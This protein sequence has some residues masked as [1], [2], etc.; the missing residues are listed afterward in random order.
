MDARLALACKGKTYTQGGYNVQDLLKIVRA[1]KLAVARLTREHLLDV[2]CRGRSRGAPPPEVQQRLGKACMGKTQSTGGLNL[3]DL[4]AIASRRGLPHSK[5][6]SR[7]ALLDKLCGK[8][9]R[10]SDAVAIG[11]AVCAMEGSRPLDLSQLSVT[12]NK[13]KYKVGGKTVTL[14]KYGEPL[15]S[16]AYGSVL[17]YCD[18]AKRYQVAVKIFYERRDE[19]DQ[20]MNNDEYDLIKQIFSGGGADACHIVNARSIKLLVDGVMYEAVVMNRMD[21]S[22]DDLVAKIP[23]DAMTVPTALNIMRVLAQTAAC[24]LANGYIY[25]DYKLANLLYRCQQDLEQVSIVY[26]DLGGLERTDGNRRWLCYSYPPWEDKNL[27]GGVPNDRIAVW[28]IALCF[29]NLFAK[30]ASDQ[31]TELEVSLRFNNIERAHDTSEIKAYLVN[32]IGALKLDRYK[33][34]GGM[35]VARLMMSMLD[36]DPATRI[37]LSELVAVLG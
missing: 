12:G 26:G 30:V 14:E 34:K 22:L 13:L 19:Y 15:G 24:L 35:S 29:V 32:F 33:T 11:P 10:P 4:R 9:D 28:G 6:M 21:G 31:V 27:E 8:R 18:S 1:R 2:L 3:A 36:E 25:T 23:A 5:S 20:L 37:S 17:L 7:R 16:G